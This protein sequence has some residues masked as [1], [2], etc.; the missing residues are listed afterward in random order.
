[1]DPECDP[2]VV[3]W[4]SGL[5]DLMA[6]IAALLIAIGGY[7]AGRR[8]LRKWR[9]RQRD[10]KRAQVAG[11]ALVA[12][13]RLLGTLETNTSAI[14][15]AVRDEAIEIEEQIGMQVGSGEN[16]HLWAS[17]IRGRWAASADAINGFYNAFYQAAG[18]L[19]QNAT[20]LLED[21]GRL[22]RD[23]ESDQKVVAQA[24]AEG[25][26]RLNMGFGDEPRKRIA[27]LQGQVKE[28]I[29]PI[30]RL[31]PDARRISL[32]SRL[33]QWWHSLFH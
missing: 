15:G 28:T 23:V 1:M 7:F 19:P 31:E 13:L 18:H 14:A 16:R 22:L 30:A 4:L 9:D 12:S 32:R 8:E 5:G 25:G 3:E 17:A 21:V 24:A 6:G 20:Q 2:T 33:A 26:P 10:E 11:E 27:E 29:G